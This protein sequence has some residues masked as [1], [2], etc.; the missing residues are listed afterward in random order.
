MQTKIVALITL[1]FFFGLPVVQAAPL[2]LFTH[3]TPSGSNNSPPPPDSLAVYDSTLDV[4]GLAGMPS[5]V[6]VQI[7]RELGDVVATLTL[8]RMI[9]REGFAER[10]A[11]ACSQGDVGACE[12][13]P[14][15]GAASEQVLLHLDRKGQRLLLA[16]DGASRPCG[17][18]HLG[19]QGTL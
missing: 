5:E 10:D 19:A 7:P 11:W 14:Y 17:R 6:L 9:R 3:I 8:E 18:R 2:S 4:V 12:L 13:I 1:C 15:P 16:P